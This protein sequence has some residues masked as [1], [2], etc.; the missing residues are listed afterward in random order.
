MSGDRKLK[1]RYL[2][3]RARKTKVICQDNSKGERDMSTFFD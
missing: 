2:K 3:T 1:N